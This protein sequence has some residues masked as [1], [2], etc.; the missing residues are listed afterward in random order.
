MIGDLIE[1]R[2][3]AISR[4]GAQ[5]NVHAPG[6]VYRTISGTTILIGS[7]IKIQLLEDRSTASQLSLGIT[8]PRGVK[9]MRKELWLKQQAARALLGA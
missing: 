9:I 8:A 6:L 7:K 5:L 1:V 2:V 3:V 4:E